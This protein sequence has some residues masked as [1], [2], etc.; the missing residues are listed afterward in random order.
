MQKA[1][2]IM[3]MPCEHTKKSIFFENDVVHDEVLLQDG[4]LVL[5]LG[6]YFGY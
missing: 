4:L 3:I 1:G 5:L 6:S 2:S